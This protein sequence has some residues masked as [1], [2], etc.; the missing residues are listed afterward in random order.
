MALLEFFALAPMARALA[1]RDLT[2]R[3]LK[4]MMLDG[5]YDEKA[6]I[7]WIRVQNY[8]SARVIGEE[9]EFGL[10]ELDPTD[11]RIVASSTG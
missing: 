6:D 3:A 1:R 9:V 5:Q 8:D 7:A 11:R 4:A 2:G 10:R